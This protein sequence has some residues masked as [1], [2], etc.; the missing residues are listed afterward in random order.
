MTTSKHL[1]EFSKEKHNIVRLMYI[2]FQ[3]NV[4][5]NK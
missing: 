4:K 1:T 3:N 2:L 5:L